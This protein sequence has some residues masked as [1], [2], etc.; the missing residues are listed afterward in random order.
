M[1][2]AVKS[3]IL[4]IRKSFPRWSGYPA[5]LP[6]GSAHEPFLYRW[7]KFDTVKSG[8]SITPGLQLKKDCNQDPSFL[9]KIDFLHFLN[10]NKKII[11][12]LSFFLLKFFSHKMF[13]VRQKDS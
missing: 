3:I 7:I 5:P 12:F 9:K 2:M 4:I 1:K 11:F 8:W 13:S 10:K 6:S